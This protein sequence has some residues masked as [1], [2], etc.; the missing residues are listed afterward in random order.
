[1]SVHI[2]CSQIAAIVS[3]P[4]FAAYLQA[5]EARWEKVRACNEASETIDEH[6]CCALTAA[7]ERAERKAYSAMVAAAK[8]FKKTVLKPIPKREREA[9]WHA[10]D[11]LVD[12]LP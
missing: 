1:M 2:I 11:V 9:I 4:E 10:L 7:D 12:E 5:I 8:H 3:A 6:G